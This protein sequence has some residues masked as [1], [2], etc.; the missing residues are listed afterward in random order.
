MS[1]RKE[2]QND[3]KPLAGRSASG[4]AMPHDMPS[5]RSSSRLVSSLTRPP[6]EL[7]PKHPQ[8]ESSEPQAKLDIKVEESS[9]P[10]SLKLAKKA[11][12]GESDLTLLRT[13]RWLVRNGHIVS[14]VLLYLFS[15]MVLFRPYEIVPG[16]TFLSGTAVFFAVA[17]LVVYLPTQLGTE[18]NFTILSTEVK[19]IL[20]L[21]FLAIVTIPIAKDPPTAWE[22][23]VDPFIKAVAIF[24]VMVNVIRTRARLMGM[25]W[26]S[27]GIGIYLS[28]AA[29]DLYRRGKFDIEDYRVAVDVGGMFGNPNEMALHLLMFTPIAIA[30]G[31]AA[32]SKAWRIL[33]FTVAVL[34]VAANMV[35]FSRGG[36]LG[37]LACLLVMAWKIGRKYRLNVTIASVLIG[38][39][40]LVAAPG[41]YGL[42]M[43]SIFI[44]GLDGVGSSDQR[45]ALLERSIQVTARNPWGIGIGNSP[46]IGYHNLQT[47]NAY[48]QVSTELG[49][50]GLLAFV[51]FMV[52]PFRKLGAIERRLFAADDLGW[53]YY[54]SIGLQA[55]IIG[56]MVSA[57]FA[58]VAYGWF[59]YYLIAYAVAFRRIYS[60]ERNLNEE[61][62]ASPFWR[63]AEAT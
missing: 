62:K 55:S 50:L 17:T 6:E 43:L 14:Y 2:K 60:I 34:F 23:F 11:K 3:Y 41:N 24:I 51:I 18:G 20:V 4:T 53:H 1:S 35:T 13:D 26:L 12:K 47:H 38:G 29:L 19:A 63:T 7:S 25:I 21:T 49:I 40:V 52:S 48:T 37:L 32:K 31:I 30:L 39:V 5:L 58:S 15:I 44:P 45:R 61:V 56:F 22:T 10:L 16:L 8:P 36:F 27:F 28:F 57:F 46:I 59:I 33:Y 9:E 54:V 42:R